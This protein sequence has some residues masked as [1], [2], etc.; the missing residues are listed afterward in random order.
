M[1]LKIKVSDRKFQEQIICSAILNKFS[2]FVT[3][4]DVEYYLMYS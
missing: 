2:I 1:F 4:I 3:D